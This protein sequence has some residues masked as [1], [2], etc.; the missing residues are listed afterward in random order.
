MLRTI[1]GLILLLCGMAPHDLY[2]SPVDHHGL[3]VD[4]HAADVCITCHDGMGSAPRNAGNASCGTA[5]SH[6]QSVEYPP[7]HKEKAF[8]SRSYVL[9]H[10]IKLK[11]NKI[12]CISCHNLENPQPKHLIVEDKNSRLCLTCHIL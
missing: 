2:A 3:M 11:N 4:F 10:G 7:K 9:S 6:P 12:V 1:I 5:Q 8:H